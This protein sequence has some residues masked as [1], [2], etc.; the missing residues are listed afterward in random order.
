VCSNKIKGPQFWNGV[1]KVRGKL[2]WGMTKHVK[3]GGQ[4]HFWEDVWV[5]QV[6]LKLTFPRLYNYCSEKNNLCQ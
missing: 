5:D 6:P 2:K 1:Q 4:T 3:S